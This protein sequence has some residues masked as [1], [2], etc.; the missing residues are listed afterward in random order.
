MASERTKLSGDLLGDEDV[1]FNV[2]EGYY[3]L[4]VYYKRQGT[5]IG[6]FIGNTDGTPSQSNIG[7]KTSGRTK[8]N[9]YPTQQWHGYKT[10]G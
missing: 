10:R 4:R 2:S 5:A 3:Y 9:S 8:Q 7:Q 1:P 6:G